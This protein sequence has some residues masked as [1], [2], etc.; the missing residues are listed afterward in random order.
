MAE[1]V[2]LP[3]SIPPLLFLLL[4]LLSAAFASMVSATGGGLDEKDEAV[5]ASFIIATGLSEEQVGRQR[6]DSLTSCVLLFSTPLLG[7]IEWCG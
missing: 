4:L 5:A 1:S 3:F 7:E 2:Y 6:Q